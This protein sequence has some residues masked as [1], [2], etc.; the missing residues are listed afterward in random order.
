M[1]PG[2]ILVKENID[3]PKVEDPFYVH[4]PNGIRN[5]K[6]LSSDKRAKIYKFLG[7]KMAQPSVY[8]LVGVTDGEKYAFTNDIAKGQGLNLCIWNIRAGKMI[9]KMGLIIENFGDFWILGTG[10]VLIES[11]GTLKNSHKEL[12]FDYGNF[13]YIS[14]GDKWRFA[15]EFVLTKEH[16]NSSDD[17]IFGSFSW[18]DQAWGG[19]KGGIRLRLNKTSN[20]NLPEK[21]KGGHEF[22]PT[23]N[24]GPQNEGEKFGSMDHKESTS[25]FYRE[26]GMCQ[27][28]SETLKFNFRFSDLGAQVGD[29]VAL[30]YW[31]GASNGHTM[32]I[33]N[34]TLW[35]IPLMWPRKGQSEKLAVGIIAEY[36][37]TP[38]WDFAKNKA[39]VYL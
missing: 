1:D 25:I 24:R 3:Q 34:F 30:Y 4:C 36:T 27:H 11:L 22:C 2:Q 32:K 6:A 18:N 23:L 28:Q 5:L 39:F 15:K 37:G 10:Q 9:Q 31:V 14:Y 29:R 13:K 7:R 8:H 33:D 16:L 26:P 19:C 17:L 20:P 21:E 12:L 38:A 35:K